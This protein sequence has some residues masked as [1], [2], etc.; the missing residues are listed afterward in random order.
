MK[1]HF[2]NEDNA[3]FYERM[4]ADMLREHYER[5][6]GLEG[7]PDVGLLKLFW[8]NAVSVLE[9]GAGEGRVIDALLE[10]GFSGRIYGLERSARLC[11]ELRKKYISCPNVTIVEHDLL[12]YTSF[13]RADTALWLW[14]GIVEFNPQEQKAT[15]HKLG[16]HVARYLCVDTPKMRS[17]TNA[18]EQC[19]NRAELQAPWG[20]EYAYFPSRDEI[21]SYLVGSNFT[22][23]KTLELQGAP[24]RVRTFYILQKQKT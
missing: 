18:T 8:E 6:S 4:P 15:I 17:Q 10:R 24:N 13:P 14:S 22:L 2:S 12:C 1:E 23:E 7:S 20:K 16:Q 11:V 19:G 3:A 9:I 5:R 21:Q